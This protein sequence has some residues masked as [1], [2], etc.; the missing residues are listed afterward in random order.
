[1]KLYHD[2]FLK[3][4]ATL[5]EINP[6]SESNDGA[7]GYFLFS[8]YFSWP[9]MLSFQCSVMLPTYWLNIVVT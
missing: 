6:M 2:V 5:I 7:G 9:L 8:S 4:D 1:M 3:Y